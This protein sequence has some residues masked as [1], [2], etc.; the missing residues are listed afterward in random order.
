[1]SSEDM[2]KALRGRSSSIW[3]GVEREN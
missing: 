3:R 2:E 1:V